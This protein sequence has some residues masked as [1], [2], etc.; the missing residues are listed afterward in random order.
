ME[1]VDIYRN[2]DAAAIAV[3]APLE[4]GRELRL[5]RGSCLAIGSYAAFA[6]VISPE[7]TPSY[8]ARAQTLA[9]IVAFAFVAVRI[10]RAAPRWSLG[11]GSLLLGFPMIAVGAGVVG[12]RVYRSRGPRELLGVAASAAAVTLVV[13]GWRH[14]LRRVGR[15]WVAAGIAVAGTLVLIQ[16]VLYPAAWALLATNRGAP[17][18][19]TDRT[20]ADLG[21]A[22]DDVRIPSHDGLELA[23]WWIPSG[24]GAAVIM[25]TGSGSTRDDV[26]QHAALL[27]RG[28]YGVLVPDFRGHGAT[29]GRSMELGWGADRDVEA[30][31]TWLEG[32]REL[33]G[34]IGVHG[35]SLGAMVAITTAAE[36][37]RIRAIVA[38]GPTSRTW[39][40]ARLAPG[41]NPLMWAS[42]WTRLHLARWLAPEEEPPPLV[43]ALRRTEAPV[44]MISSDDER[45]Q[46]LISAYAHAAP[47]TVTAW[48][49]ADTPHAL[50]AFRHP[51]EYRARVLGLFDATLL[52]QAAS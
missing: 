19:A 32:R 50:A 45:E 14:L 26:L 15:P 42:W 18:V 33:T 21:L 12:E 17:P 31:V 40:D 47:E 16:L 8:R 30:L 9:L 52:D 35:L 43:E 44:L 48:S 2:R 24:N 36:D 34:G 49:L 38:E 51:E 41:M 25:L 37:P 20:P 4:E 28:G 7:G 22:F 39:E 11:T 29:P 3:E 5:R 6:L 23:A 46:G 10:V 13:L 27:A 1:P